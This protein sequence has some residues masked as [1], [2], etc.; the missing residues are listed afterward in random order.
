MFVTN[1]NQ[2][3]HYWRLENTRKLYPSIGFL[4]YRHSKQLPSTPCFS[5]VPQMPVSFEYELQFI[6]S[7]TNS[8]TTKEPCAYCW[9]D[10]RWIIKVLLKSHDIKFP[11]L[12]SSCN[13]NY[14]LQNK[15]GGRKVQTNTSYWFILLVLCD[16]SH[17][18]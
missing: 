3:S 11:V 6:L 18:W 2:L 10:S 13:N 8:S 7:S 12:S 5:L 14:P 16:L 4:K 1:W 15:I 9:L 17:H